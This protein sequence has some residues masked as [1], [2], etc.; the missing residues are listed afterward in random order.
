MVINKINEKKAKPLAISISVIFL[1]IFFVSHICNIKIGDERY[2]IM[3]KEVK[4]SN[5]TGFDE[6]DLKRLAYFPLLEEVWYKNYNMS[7]IDWISG[8]NPK[9]KK[10]HVS[11]SY[12]KFNIEALNDTSIEYIFFD[13][14]NIDDFTDARDNRT[15]KE[16]ITWYYDGANLN[17]IENFKAL[18]NLYL[19]NA[20][21]ITNC[22]ALKEC[23]ELKEVSLVQCDL[24][25]DY[26]SFLE[27]PKLEYLCVD[28]GKLCEEEIKALEDKG[29][30]V[31]FNKYEPKG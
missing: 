5:N 31:A 10:C 11:G 6:A 21:K 3:C 13:R 2:F 24:L 28:E 22:D 12:N 7:D 1:I 15:I 29:V 8:L 18:E 30:R 20:H 17:G 26:S 16:I 19:A 14:L 23:S 4:I 25:E 27:I 9:V